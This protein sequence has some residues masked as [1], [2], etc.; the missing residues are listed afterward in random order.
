M[1]REQGKQR[2]EPASDLE[3]V[4]ARFVPELVR[5]ALALGLSSFFT[6]EE[7]FRKALG[8][9]VPKDWVDFA[10]GQGERW[11]S[12]LAERLGAEFGR[13]L[14]RLDLAELAAAVL[15]GRTI[16]VT[17]QVRLKPRSEE[18]RE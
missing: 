5:R 16:E 3:Q 4:D 6:T 18:D 11:R 13:A 17:A 8:D 1:A 14:E 7:A 2:R 12:Q 10:S 9:T 15:E